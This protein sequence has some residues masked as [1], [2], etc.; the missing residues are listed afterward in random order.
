MHETIGG[1]ISARGYKF[2]Q[3]LFLMAEP[4][5]CQF[6]FIK[7]DSSA[8]MTY[9][10][11]YVPYMFLHHGGIAIRALDNPAFRYPYGK[12]LFKCFIL[13]PHPF[14]LRAYLHRIASYILGNHTLLAYRA[15]H[16]WE[17]I[18]QGVYNC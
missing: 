8:G 17:S 16:H 12:H 6:G 4:E 9:I 11:L 10:Q 5:F 2:P 18:A 3:F 15:V 1:I 13:C 7:P 14:A